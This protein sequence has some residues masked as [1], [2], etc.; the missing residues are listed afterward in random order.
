VR[1]FFRHCQA[2][3][4]AGWTF[5]I[6]ILLS[7][8]L[9][10]TGRD[11]RAQANGDLVVRKLSFVGNHAI[12]DDVLAASI[13]TT[14]SA[15]LATSPI[16]RWMGLGEK[17]YFD[18]VDFERDVFRIAVLYRKSGYPD[19]VVDT[20]VRRTPED[21]YLTFKITEGEPVRVQS[22]QIT[23]LDSL[24]DEV[25]Q[26]V[27]VDLPMQEGD[28]FSRIV[29]QAAA[30][31]IRFR[32][33]NRGYPTADVLV[34]YILRTTERRASVT[35]DAVPG[36]HAVVGSVHVTGTSRTTSK[37]VVSL[38]T[39]RPG[40]EYARDDLFESQ[41][42]LYNSDLFR[43]ASVNV[44][45]TRFVPGSDSVPLLVQVAEA[46]PR[47]ARASV[48][49]GTTDCLRGS[50]GI[51]FRNFLGEGRLL[52]L[53][54][55]VAKI[56]VGSPTDWGLDKT[57]CHPVADDTIGSS[58][59]TYNLT[60]TLRRP[61]F[62]SP[63][64]T[65]VV[66]AYVERRSEFKVYRRQEFG[67]SVGINRETPVHRLPLSL[68]YN[69]SLGR[70]EASPFIFCAF[71]NACNAGDVSFLSQR[72]RLAAI[73]ASGAIPRSNNPI[74][75]SRG[76]VAS[77]ELTVASRFIG[78][79]PV[80][81]FTRVV[82]D[83][84]AYHP[85]GRSMVFSWHVHAGAIFSP[86]ELERSLASFV[87]P[88]ERFYAGGPSDIRGFPRNLLGPVVY[89][90]TRTHL[91]SMTSA[92]KPLDRDSVQIYPTGG[93][94]VAVANVELRMPSPVFGERM[95]LAAFVDAGTMW[96]RGVTSS[97]IVVTPGVGL[98]IATPLGPA[99]LDVAYNPR[100]LAPG[101][102]FI[103]EPDNSLTR[104]ATRTPYKPSGYGYAVHFAVGQPF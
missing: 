82:G 27:T 60:A 38:L 20:L 57:I 89:V 83:F 11:A 28:V 63:N 35:L 17:R 45:T 29:M 3:P 5:R 15:T 88:E 75:P 96:E 56:G 25:R 80:Q 50:A 37:T 2:P 97:R 68:S 26:E 30:D 90:T 81:Q 8:V 21:I 91:D 65:A 6:L 58:K 61:A 100:G 104:D 12:S 44:D 71:F 49:Y 59:L 55:R 77:G 92:G 18:Q 19:V 22:F 1:S 43:L 31:T 13:V 95:R 78:S 24:P 54:T 98:R 94:T 103:V 51:T 52:D 40:E 48:G 10:G 42:N 62:L 9:L 46:E 99:R 85:I 76:F 41:R 23:G 7:L 36:Q 73:S 87:P 70:T 74:D 33:E 79:D 53:S 39:A 84:A 34:S 32:L 16:F 64:N 47:R 4:A 66:S 67:A 101:Q 14:K 69:L 86:V 93:N 72:R 102:F